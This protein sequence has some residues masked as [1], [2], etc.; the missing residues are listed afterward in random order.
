MPDADR[1]DPYQRP[2]HFDAAAREADALSRI[3]RWHGPGEWQAVMLALARDSDARTEAWAAATV[4][5]GPAATVLGEVDA[6]R[7]GA[8]RR[9]FALM[10]QRALTWAPALRHARVREWRQRAGRF[11]PSALAPWRAVALHHVLFGALPPRGRGE[12]LAIQA[13]AAHAATRVLVGTMGLAPDDQARWLAAALDAL[14]GAGA[15]RPSSG[16]GLAPALPVRENQL[17]LRVRRLALMQ[18]PLLVRAWI[19][20][21]RATDLLADRRV[22]DALHLACLALDLP[23]L[24]AL[25]E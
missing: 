1:N 22:G 24:A 19:E 18:R 8:R 9:V 14:A 20:A 10:L 2:V 17:A 4:G 3:G 25:L 12:A 23:P 7:D 16:A 15:P 6:L 5:I 13:H 11:V 21:S